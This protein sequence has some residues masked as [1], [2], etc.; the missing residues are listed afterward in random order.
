MEDAPSVDGSQDD[1]Y[2]G[3]SRRRSSKSKR[4]KNLKQNP[5]S[6]SEARAIK[7][8]EGIIGDTFPTVNPHWLLYNG[9]TLELDGYNKDKRLALEFS[10]PLHTKWF[11]D[12]E[13]YTKY[14]E[15]IVKDKVKITSCKANGV[16]LIVLD[17]TLP[18]KHWYNYI[19]SRLYDYSRIDKPTIYIA[20]QFAEPFRNPQLEDELKLVFP[21]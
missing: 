13:S 4:I 12:R 8:L 2:N 7:I 5:R 17:M 16:D 6:K 10:G 1:E 18:N 19:K 3:G 14:F 9:R 20:E 21:E 15:R 11:P